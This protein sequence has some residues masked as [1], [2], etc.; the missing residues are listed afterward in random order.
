MDNRSIG[1][2][3][4][5]ILYVLIHFSC[6]LIQ[7][8]CVFAILGLQITLTVTETCAYRIGVG[9]WSAPFLLAAPISIWML[10]WKQNAFYCFIAFI[11]HIFSTLLAS[12]VIIIS[13][14]ALIGQI[15]SPCSTSSSSNNYFLSINISLIGVTVLFKSFIY[16]EIIVLYRLQRYIHEPPIL[17]SY[18][19]NYRIISEDVNNKAWDSFGSIITKKQH[20][21]N[22]VDV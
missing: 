6:S 17:D 3:F 11:I 13:F 20:S 16:A 15:G 12:I 19:K 4:R 2:R 14:I 8:A 10:I 21:I 22:D 1:N 18:E 7:L 9:F 5:S